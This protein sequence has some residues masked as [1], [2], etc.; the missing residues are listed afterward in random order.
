MHEDFHKSLELALKQKIPLNEAEKQVFGFSHTQVTEWLTSGWSLPVEIFLPLVHH[1]QLINEP[2]HLDIISLTH[3]ADWLCYQCG[4]TIGKNY[5]SPELDSNSIS[6]L[7]LTENDIQ[8]VIKAFA[9]EIEKM[10]L[11]FDIASN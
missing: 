10:S 11:F 5:Q 8:E 3:L 9:S 7:M 4:M 2:Q 6:H 1:H